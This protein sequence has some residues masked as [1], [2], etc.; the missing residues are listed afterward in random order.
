MLLLLLLVAAAVWAQVPADEEAPPA[1]DVA[2]ATPAD[3]D[4]AAADA[5]AVDGEDPLAAIEADEAA[6]AEVDGEGM[7]RFE[8]SERI[9]EDSSVAYPNDI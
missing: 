6:G 1:E 3:P 2:E 7:D 8:P 9:S 5:A 4:G